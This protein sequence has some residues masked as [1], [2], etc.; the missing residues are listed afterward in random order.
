MHAGNLAVNGIAGLII[1]LAGRPSDGLIAFGTGTAGGV[2]QILTQPWG[3]ARD[4]KDYRQQF[5]GQALRPR[6]DLY[7]TALAGSGA[8]A[9]LRWSW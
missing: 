2:I 5:G 6:L 1:G 3:P 9:G 4:W 8:Q 7:V